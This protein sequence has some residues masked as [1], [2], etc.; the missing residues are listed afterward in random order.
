MHRNHARPMEGFVLPFR[1]L[2]I[3]VV[4]LLIA[5]VAWSQDE[6][7]RTTAPSGVVSTSLCGDAYVLALEPRVNIAALSWQAGGS[8]STAPTEMTGLAKGKADGETL[9][10]FAG[11]PVVLG[12]GDSRR[13]ESWTKKT[14]S[15]VFRLVWANDFAQVESNLYNLGS[16]LHR[17][18]QAKTIIT[19]LQERLV[20]LTKPHV[21]RP[22]VLY[23]TPTLG[24]AGKGTWVDA[25]IRV[26]GGDNMAEEMGVVGWGRVRLEELARQKPDLI[27]LSYFGDGPPSVLNFRTRHP[28]LRHVLQTTPT[29]TVP[30]KDWVCGTPN[31]IDASE[32][33]S[34]AIGRLPE[35]RL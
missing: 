9:V 26:A 14:G 24:T 13:A 33:I 16:F 4:F 32:K 2:R 17:E 7:I 20:A 31:L 18:A 1:L 27:V 3:A 15:P 30:G 22:K 6:H 35:P 29:V 21:N 34:M 10:R 23:V 25:A 19:R 5:P 8:L 28:F 11:K 12:P